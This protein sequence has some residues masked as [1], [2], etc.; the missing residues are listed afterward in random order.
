MIGVLVS[1][2]NG[3]GTFVLIKKIVKDNDVSTGRKESRLSM[4]EWPEIGIFD[5][6]NEVPL[7]NASR[8]MNLLED[9]DVEIYNFVVEHGND[10]GAHEQIV[11][12][13]LDK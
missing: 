12:V 2:G 1:H 3:I 7:A 4:L 11:S 9:Y 8:L 13:M 10:D 6:D 5:S